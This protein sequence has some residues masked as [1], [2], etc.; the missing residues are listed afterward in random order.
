MF[1]KITYFGVKLIKRKILWLHHY[2]IVDSYTHIKQKTDHQ[3]IV[4]NLL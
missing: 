3:N 4:T 1:F 2:I